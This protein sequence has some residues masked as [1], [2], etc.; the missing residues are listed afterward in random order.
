MDEYLEAMGE[1]MVKAQDSLKFDLSKVRTGRASP[2]LVDTVQVHVAS[3]G[4]VMPLQE[5]ATIK[6]T[7]ARMLVVTPWDKSTIPDIEKGIIA[8]G[9]GLNPSNDGKIVRIPVPPLSQER[10]QELVRMVRKMAEDAKVRLRKVRREYNDIFKAA[11][12]DGDVSEDDC[13]RLLAQVQQVTDEQVVIVDQ[14]IAEKEAELL[15]V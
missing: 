11:E 14:V 12:K 7:D 5:L 15:E 6:A 10:R 9:L 8:A 1:D 4:A 3:Y 2:K 13:R